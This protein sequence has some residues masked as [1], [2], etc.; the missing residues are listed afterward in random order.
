MSLFSVTSP[1]AE[2][3]GLGGMYPH[4]LKI[5]AS[6]FV[7]ICIAIVRMGGGGI[8]NVIEYRLRRDWRM[9]VSPSR[10]REIASPPIPNSIF[11]GGREGPRLPAELAHTVL[12]KLTPEN[13]F[14][15]SI[16]YMYLRYIFCYVS[17][18][19]PALNIGSQYC[20]QRYFPQYKDFE[21]G[22]FCTF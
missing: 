12:V 6:K 20:L 13:P 22:F 9:Q 15:E 4:F 11:F 17:V 21:I 14:L 10:Q 19:Y 16:L 2:P 1:V 8:E 3:W 5:P 18:S 7:Q